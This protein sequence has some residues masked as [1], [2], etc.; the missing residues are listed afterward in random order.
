MRCVF[1]FSHVI[2]E[3]NARVLVFDFAFLFFLFIFLF[4]WWYMSVFFF[5]TLAFIDFFVVQ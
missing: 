1:V 3:S 5:Q 2:L 4:I